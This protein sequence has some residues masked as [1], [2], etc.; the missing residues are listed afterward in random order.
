MIFTKHNSRRIFVLFLGI[1]LSLTFAFSPKCVMAD[2]TTD[3]TQD[4]ETMNIYGIYLG[5]V[6]QGDATLVESDGEYLLM[7]VGQYESYSYVK[8][9]LKSRGVTKLSVYI[10]HL[11]SDHTGGY[12]EG[13]GFDKLCSDFDVEKL[14]LPS[15]DVFT[16]KVALKA[17]M[18]RYDGL[19]GLFIENGG[20]ESNIIYLN[21]GDSFSFGDV[22]VNIIGPVGMEN[23]TNADF[24]EETESTDETDATDE[25]DETDIDETADDI[26]EDGSESE[27]ELEEDTTS[28]ADSEDV[29][30]G[31]VTITNA[32][33]NNLSLIAQF[34]CGDVTFLTTG[35]TR[36]EEEELLVAEY[37]SALKCDILK[38]A[39]HG[40]SSSSTEEF[41]ACA[42]PTY[43]FIL[44]SGEA[45]VR[46]KYSNG[47]TWRKTYKAR[48]N[49]AEYGIVYSVGNET[50][51]VCYKVVNGDIGMYTS[52]D[53]FKEEL[54]GLIK[55]YGGFPVPSDYEEIENDP[56]L[57]NYYLLDDEGNILTG[58]HEIDGKLYYFGPGGCMETGRYYLNFDIE[59]A[60]KP[61]TWTTVNG[62]KELRF[63]NQTT[64]E[65]ETGWYRYRGK[66]YYLDPETGA[67]LTGVCTVDGDKYYF[68]STGVLQTSTWK[69]TSAGVRYFGI[70]GRLVKS[71]W[72]TKGG[73][74]YYLDTETGYR[75]TGVHWIDG[76]AY[77]FNS[78]GVMQTKV[79]KTTH[80]GTRYFGKYGDM[81]TGKV[82]INGVEYEFDEQTGYLIK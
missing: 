57:Y 39:H 1:L 28:D 22:D 76:K 19:T 75:Y 16:D 48:R 43:S 61:Y 3:E 30:V 8:K 15:Y 33:I 5:T 56:Y 49:A 18:E 29:E 13:K 35:D 55:L 10:S 80:R 53:K 4:D 20:A 64:A 11:H 74:T 40:T 59:I 77:Y 54:T 82:T 12:T 60:Y 32:Y 25:I 73:K 36:R 72:F 78:K 65:L 37:G 58:T 69:K 2:D 17:F 45:G 47:L 66:K 51:D 41:M 21:T 68:S 81:K 9:F 24:S 52:K 42:Q 6:A 23:Y 14:Y 67:A 46:W 79:W 7:D 34:K 26:T 62:V 50:Y 70:Y 27:L 44:N 31:D 63:Y 38:I 71:G